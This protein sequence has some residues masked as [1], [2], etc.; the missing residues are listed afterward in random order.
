MGRVILFVCTGNTCRS[1][2]AHVLLEKELKK[3]G[4]GKKFAIISAG[5]SA[6]GGEPATEE[7][8]KALSEIQLDLKKHR[9]RI[10]T[11][12]LV[13]EA[14]LI[15]TMTMTHKERVLS[16][17]PD[18]AE[19]VFTLKEY[20]GE[21]DEELLAELQEIDREEV[22][23]LQKFQ[24]EKGAEEDKLKKERDELRRK[25]KKVE[26]KLH[27]L[28][29]QREELIADLKEKRS[30]L[31]KR[32]QGLLDISDPFGQDLKAYIETRDELDKS[33]S[34]L[35]SRLIERQVKENE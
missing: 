9:A 3:K 28:Q 18:S 7:A 25:L 29:I 16:M 30:H 22:K 21:G 19:K 26:D 1:P 23:R 35:A 10:L 33:I 11:P 8:V 12:K 24:R 20:L 31:K 17:V 4:A 14:D 13:E 32:C 27:F 5:I 15:L 34:R 6:P 2:M